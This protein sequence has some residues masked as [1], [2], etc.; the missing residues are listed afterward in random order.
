MSLLKTKAKESVKAPTKSNGA[1]ET[2]EL[3]AAYIFSEEDGTKMIQILGELPSKYFQGYVGPMLQIF[4]QAFRGDMTLN[5]PVK[6]VGPVGVEVEKAEPE[7]P[8]SDE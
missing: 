5:V 1:F 8:Q 6:Q 3:K 2:K 7:K 4:Q